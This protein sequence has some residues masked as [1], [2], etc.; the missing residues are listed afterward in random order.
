[1]KQMLQ[2]LVVSKDESREAF[3]LPTTLFMILLFLTFWGVSF[4]VLVNSFA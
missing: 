1:M 2:R 3:H 4:Y